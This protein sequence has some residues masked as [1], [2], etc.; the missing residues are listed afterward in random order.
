MKKNKNKKIIGFTCGAFDLTH[1]GHYL[2]FQEIKNECDYL[3][4]GLQSDPSIDRKE[5]NKPI[6][7]KKE[8]EIQLK[9]CKF[10]DKVINYKTEK[11]LVKIL[12]KLKPDVRFLGSDWKNKNF[13][14]KDLPIKIVFN[15]RDH[16]FSSSNLRKKIFN[17]E[18]KKYKN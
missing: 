4:V 14:G 2:M 6:Q 7:S 12:K 5:K 1:A 8:R 16:S 17:E 11:D 13:T 10:I 15:N 18:Y 9:S 3:I